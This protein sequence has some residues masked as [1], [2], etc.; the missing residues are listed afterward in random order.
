MAKNLFVAGLSYDTTSDALNKHFSEI[1]TVVSAQVIMDKFSNQSKGFG[2]VEM[3]TEE[4]GKMAMDKL[5]GTKLND[6]NIV[7]KEAR[8]RENFGN[9]G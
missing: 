9:R 6:R 5:N 4:E 3:S 7:V 1:G 2:F 8:P